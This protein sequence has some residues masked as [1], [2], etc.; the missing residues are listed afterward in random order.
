M[1]H[2]IYR[3]ANDIEAVLARVGWAVENIPQIRVFSG[4]FE[5]GGI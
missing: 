5:A 4:V 3:E 1:E 2:F